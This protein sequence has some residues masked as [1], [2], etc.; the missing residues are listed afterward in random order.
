MFNSVNCAERLSVIV[1]MII[2]NMYD[3]VT[4]LFYIAQ[5]CVLACEDSSS[6]AL[7]D[8]YRTEVLSI[9]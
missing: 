4:D 8:T 6:T 2:I 7:D 9:K 5:S 1:I 3:I